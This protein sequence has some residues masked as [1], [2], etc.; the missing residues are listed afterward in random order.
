M[1]DQEL[2]SK[3]FK[4][5]TEGLEWFREKKKKLGTSQGVIRKSIKP[6]FNDPHFNWEVTIYVRGTK[7]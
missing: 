5:K 4:E 1:I 7:A 3:L 6:V 2:D